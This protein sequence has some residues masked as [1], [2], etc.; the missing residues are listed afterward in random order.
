MS[1]KIMVKVRPFS[2]LYDV[3]EVPGNALARSIDS[4]HYYETKEI[5]YLGSE[6]PSPLADFGS[7]AFVE[8][9]TGLEEVIGTATVVYIDPHNAHLVDKHRAL[10]PS[11]VALLIHENITKQ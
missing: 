8:V 5:L 7:F 9:E 6:T 11:A 3:L 2:D 4:K 10:G 1:N